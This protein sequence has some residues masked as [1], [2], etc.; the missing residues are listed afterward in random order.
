MQVSVDHVKLPVEKLMLPEV[1]IALKSDTLM[2]PSGDDGVVL[3]RQ[4]LPLVTAKVPELAEMQQEQAFLQLSSHVL[5]CRVS[6]SFLHK[7]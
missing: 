2:G 3:N 7:Q 1:S 5:T 6:R 4:N